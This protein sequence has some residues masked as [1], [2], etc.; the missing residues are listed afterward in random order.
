MNGIIYK[1]TNKVNGKRYVGQTK[2]TLEQRI[3]FHVGDVKR[4]KKR[5]FICA[6]RNYG[7]QSF[8]FEI[9]D[10]SSDHAV[11]D[12]KEIYWI[13]RLKCRTHQHGYNIHAGGTNRTDFTSLK[14]SES[15]KK[16][17][18]M[19]A[20][21][22]AK[23]SA[24]N[25]GKQ[26]T[27]GWKISA[28]K[29]GKK[30]PD[31]TGEKHHMFG[32]PSPMRGRQFTKEQVQHSKDSWTPERHAAHA[33]RLRKRWDRPGE[34]ER[35]AAS[36]EGKQKAPHTEQAKAK[37]RLVWTQPERKAKHLD[38]MEKL[39]SDPSFKSDVSAKI[40][41]AHST[42]E[43]K[44]KLSNALKHKWASYTTEQRQARINAAK[45]GMAS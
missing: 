33:D 17:P 40:K 12:E 44:Q 5:A 7:I 36:M 20:E 6:L 14:M 1:A 22:R 8:K 23:I 2:M 16:K 37:L 42:S 9:I 31:I 38:Q 35:F 21:T 32:K 4:G 10:G 28:G 15:A 45:K 27:P 34:R 13:A 43:T 18:P 30:R 24:A 3:A 39:W 26:L 25:K 19:S 41:A 11:L 29:M